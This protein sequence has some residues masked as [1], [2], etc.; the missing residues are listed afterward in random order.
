MSVEQFLVGTVGKSIF[1]SDENLANDNAGFHNSIYRGKY[2]GTAPTADMYAVISAGTFEDLFIGDYFAESA[3]ASQ[4]W[5]I[6]AFD[7]YLH[8]GDTDCTT[9]HVVIVPDAA[10]V[11]A[12]LNESGG[13]SGAYVGC[14]FYKGTNS[15]TGLSSMN[16]AIAAVF[17][18]AHILAH[19]IYLPNAV[20]NGYE[21]GGAWCETGNPNASPKHLG[22]LMN[23]I[24]VYGSNIFHNVIN[25]TNL[26]MNY[27]VEKSQ[28]PLFQ[29]RHDLIGNR[30]HWWLRDV[31]SSSHFARVYYHGYADC[32]GSSHS[33]GVRPAFAIRA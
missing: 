1:A 20:T 18:E 22:E 19:K 15:N 16:T 23:E 24:M 27:T 8:N 29:H 31:V 10:I 33:I 4:K 2:L 17:G 14:D 28:L 26:P 13:V 3:D 21:S 9:H 6:A 30:G 12:K 11:S 32:L 7:Y 5:R 25:G